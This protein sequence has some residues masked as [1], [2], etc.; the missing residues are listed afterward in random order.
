MSDRAPSP[1]TWIHS[2][3]GEIVMPK[4]EQ[5]LPD[6]SDE[7]TYV[8]IGS[9]NT[10]SK[11]VVEPKRLS[12]THAPTRARQRL[13]PGDVLV[14]MTRPNLNAVAKVTPDL[15]GAIG[16]T[17]FCVLRSETVDSDW[18]FYR[19]QARDFIEAMVDVVQGALYPAVRPKDIHAFPLH[20]PPIHDQRQIVAD[21]ETQFARLDDAVAS[22]K[23]AQVRLKRYRASV[24]GGLR[25]A[26]GANRSRVGPTGGPRIRTG[27]RSVGADQGGARGGIGEGA[28]QERADT[29]ST[30]IR[31]RSV[32]V[33]G[34]RRYGPYGRR[35]HGGTGG[36]GVGDSRS[37]VG[38]TSKWFVRASGPRRD[39]PNTTN[40]RG[41]T[42]QTRFRA[43]ALSQDVDR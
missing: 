32:A 20:T 42:S 43:N 18:L 29:P 24:E 3:I 35:R 34:R 37:I 11:R 15:K 7:F 22:L 9:V 12:K 25:G 19:V 21:I 36:L 33:D 23:R 26:A 38:S 41:A 1:S 8:D 6:D 27:E 13:K 14:S 39:Y 16:S 40:Q 4:V 10:Q 30:R 17:G 31:A 2:T 5:G 28:R